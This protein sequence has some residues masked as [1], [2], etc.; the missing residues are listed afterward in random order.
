M[1]WTEFL[2]KWTPLSGRYIAES[3]EYVNIADVAARSDN[4]NLLAQVGDGNVYQAFWRGE[5]PI[6]GSVIFAQPIATGSI[7]GLGFGGVF[8]GG[9]IEY[10]QILGATIGATLETLN[11]YNADR[12]LIGTL[13]FT[14]DNPVLMVDSVTGGTIVDKSFGLTPDTGAGSA[15]ANLASIGLGGIFDINSIPV[16]KLTN[17]GSKVAQL[18]LTWIWKERQE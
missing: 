7:R 18:A 3:G 4:S 14:S 12:R 10:E 17:N 11:G 1:A 5:I 6:G 16:F 13:E 2:R 15:A 8:T 9:I